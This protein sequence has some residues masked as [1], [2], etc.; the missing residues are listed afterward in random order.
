MRFNTTVNTTEA[1]M[2]KRQPAERKRT[3]MG[4]P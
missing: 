1:M 3:A 2:L 4:A